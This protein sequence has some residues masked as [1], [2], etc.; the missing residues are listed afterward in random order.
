MEEP[1]G[2]NGKVI[3]ERC[4]VTSRADCHRSLW[5]FLRDEVSVFGNYL[6]DC[7]GSRRSER[8]FKIATSVDVKSGDFAQIPGGAR[9]SKHL[10]RT[11][12]AACYDDTET[13]AILSRDWEVGDSRR[14]STA[15]F[16]H[17][18][19]AFRARRCGLPG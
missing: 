7:L 5:L 2:G 6:P 15:T 16:I 12:G 3:P 14:T 10:H 18:T 19:S 4:R 9:V 1:G 11:G 17:S 13:G 8:P